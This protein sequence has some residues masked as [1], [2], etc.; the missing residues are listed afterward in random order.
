MMPQ[1]AQ[2]TLSLRAAGVFPAEGRGMANAAE[3]LFTSHAIA[4][5]TIRSGLAANM[6]RRRF[7]AAPVARPEN[8]QCPCAC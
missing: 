8:F 3:A 6:A 2:A 1:N 4:G 7:N 5:G